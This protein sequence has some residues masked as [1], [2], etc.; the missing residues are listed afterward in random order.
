MGTF[1]EQGILEEQEQRTSWVIV[2]GMLGT[3]ENLGDRH[4]TG[5]VM[6]DNSGRNWV[7]V[8]EG[9]I[10]FQD[11]VYLFMRDTQKQRHRQRE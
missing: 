3:W 4:F 1:T 10:L 5:K 6:E 11:F 7:W 9:F 8:V 2:L